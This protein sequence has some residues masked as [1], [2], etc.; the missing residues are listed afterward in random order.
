MMRLDVRS[1]LK[2]ALRPRNGLPRAVPLVALLGAAAP[3]VGPTI[4]C[5]GGNG[6]L[7]ID[8]TRGLGHRRDRRGGAA[9]VGC[10]PDHDA[11]LNPHPVHPRHTGV[12][13]AARPGL[14]AR[15]WSGIPEPGRRTRIQRARVRTVRQL[16]GV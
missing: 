4:R 6:N 3:S 9:R 2:L 10:G 8:R 14:A 15:Y 11:H 1:A 5:S 12:G 7:A 16:C 13:P